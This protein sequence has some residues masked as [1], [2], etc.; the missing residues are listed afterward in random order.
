MNKKGHSTLEKFKNILKLQNYAPN[1]IS[2]YTHYVIEFISSYKKPAL[3][4]TGKDVRFYIEN[5]N[6]TSTSQQNQIYS[7]LKL[8]SRYVLNIKRIDNIILKRPKKEKKLPRIIQKKKLLDSIFAIKNLKHKAI[9][10][11]AYSTGLRVSEVINLKIR[12]VDSKRML[13]HINQAKGRKDRTVPLSEGLLQILRDYAKEYCPNATPDDY[14]FSGQF[15]DQYSATSCNKIVK[16]YID[17]SATMHLL[18]HSCFTHLLESGIDIR[19]IQKIAG[20]SSSKTTEIYTHVSTD[21]L[22]TVA[23]PI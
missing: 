18:R 15:S 3:H 6:Y 17:P 2:I 11:L 4:I 12:D 20:H 16:K 5:Y 19:I 10:S 22:K 1:S 8:F 7:A 23:M 13:L 21:L 9:L 14:V